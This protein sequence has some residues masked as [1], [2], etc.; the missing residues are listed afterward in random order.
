MMGGERSRRGGRGALVGAAAGWLLALASG[1]TCAQPAEPG[2]YAR[3]ETDQGEFLCRLHYETVPRTV[4]NFAGLAEGTQAWIDFLAGDVAALPFYDGLIFHRVIDG[5]MIQSGSPNGQGDD[6]PGYQ[7]RDEFHAS[8][9]HDAPGV[10]SMANSGA[11][12][13][14]S[15]FFVTVAATPWLDDK[16]SV[17]GRVVE[18]MAVVDALSHVATD[19]QTDRPLADVL[20]QRVT[21]VRVGAEAEAFDPASVQPPLPICRSKR[22][23]IALE[24]AGLVVGWDDFLENSDY[25]LFG[26]SAPDRAHLW[27]T[28]YIGPYEGA[29]V[30]GLL[31][32][33][34]RYFFQ[35]AEVEY[36]SGR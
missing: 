32:A 33:N 7:F 1:G 8:L 6:G 11:N 22:C 10:L 4:A 27:N 5:F 36:W 25:F 17:F 19:P 16:H 28:Y 15:Q 18:G 24:T 20:L 26:S 12:T 21:I 29:V 23:W 13:N 34:P 9:R 31:A 35:A 3:F 2:L 14:G 30:G